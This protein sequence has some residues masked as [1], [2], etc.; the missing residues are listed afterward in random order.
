MH[1]FLDVKKAYDT[2]WRKGLWY[3]MW[4]MGIKGK[5]WRVV[6]SLYV[7]NRSCVYLDGKSSEFFTVN[8][9]V[10]QGCTLSPTLFLIYI[11]GLLCEIEKSQ[12]LGVKFS[13]N[14][15]PGLLFADDFVGVA[16]SKLALQSMITIIYNYSRRWRFEAN[17]KKCAVVVFSKIGDTS[18]KWFW[19]N[20]ELRVLDSYCYLGIIFSLYTLY[21]I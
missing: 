4:E 15:M 10:A 9:G 7:N 2:V 20:K 12:H 1:F 14:N 16:E 21:W 17:V 19:G 3:K 18:G 6:R 11:N 5:M 8:Q 13:E